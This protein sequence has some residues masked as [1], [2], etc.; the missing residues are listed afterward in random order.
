MSDSIEKMFF[1]AA[2]N[3]YRYTSK[4]GAIST[5]QLFD[6]PLT[7]ESKA[8]LND[9]AKNINAKIKAAEEEDF[10]NPTASNTLLTDK[11]AIVKAVIAY[12]QERIAAKEQAKIRSTEKQKA[13]HE[14]AKRKD[15]KYSDMSDDELKALAGD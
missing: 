13:Q 15:A 1:K 6:L 12:K 11:L 10:V 14:L 3:K 7:H 9:I 8:N 5:E 2:I 4:V